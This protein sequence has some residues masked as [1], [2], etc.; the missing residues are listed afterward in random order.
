MRREQRLALARQLRDGPDLLGQQDVAAFGFGHAVEPLTA[1]GPGCARPRDSRRSA[2]PWSRRPP[3]GRP[4]TRQAR[5]AGNSS[6]NSVAQSGRGSGTIASAVRVRRRR[7]S[8]G[9][10]QPAMASSPAAPSAANRPHRRSI[11]GSAHAPYRSAG[12]AT[13]DNVNAASRVAAFVRR[14][15]ERELAIS[16]AV[17]RRPIGCRAMKARRAA[18]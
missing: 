8:S 12:H 10:A 17:P 16:M 5:I 2:T 15:V 9:A 3:A 6:G 7:R 4:V 13:V 18:S 1:P 11:F 14:Q